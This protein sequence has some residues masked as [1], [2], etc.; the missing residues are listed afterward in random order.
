MAKCFF[1]KK[2]KEIIRYTTIKRSTFYRQFFRNTQIMSSVERKLEM[3]L[4]SYNHSKRSPAYRELRVKYKSLKRTHEQILDIL[5]LLTQNIHL[6]K[7]DVPVVEIKQEKEIRG[8]SEPKTVEIGESPERGTSV[9]NSTF[10]GVIPISD[11]WS[12][13]EL[14]KQN[15]S[16]SLLE[17]ENIQFT[18]DDDDD[19]VEEVHLDRE[20]AEF[21]ALEA[22]VS[23]E[24]A[25]EAAEAAAEA[26]ADV[27]DLEVVFED[28]LEDQN[29]ADEEEVEVEADEEEVE[30]EADEE[31]VEVEAD[32]EEVEVDEEV[33]EVEE[34]EEEVEEVVEV[35][36]EQDEVEEEEEDGVYEVE[37]KGVR[38]YTTNEQDGVVY[39][40][41]END[42][43][44]DIVGK[45]VKGKLVLNK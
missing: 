6:H 27:E 20:I 18:V 32:E 11:L 8:C 15:P 2:H 36:E 44:G 5:T 9:G 14:R 41:D 30:V 19:E 34:E 33:E 7:P 26:E 40:V 43:V 10:S 31:E 35:E 39:S 23:D 13:D 16:E 17:P 42:D 38:Y 1:E 29:E 12:P 3:L 45:F 24:A 28:E 22:A 25:D 4:E 21:V 37:I